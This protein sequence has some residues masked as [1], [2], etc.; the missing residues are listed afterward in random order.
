MIRLETAAEIVARL[1]ET[2]GEEYTADAAV[3]EYARQ[4]DAYLAERDGLE[5]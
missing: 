1:R 2:M 3:E 5:S 4:A